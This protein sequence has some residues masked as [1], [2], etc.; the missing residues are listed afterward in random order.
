MEVFKTGGEKDLKGKLPLHLVPP[1]IGEA[2]AEVSQVGIQKGYTPRNWEKGLPIVEGHLAAMQR[3]VNEYLKGFDLNKEELTD[4]TFSSSHHL[5]HAAWHLNAAVTQVMR[6]RY[7]LDDRPT[8]PMQATLRRTN[9]SVRN[10]FLG[11]KGS[12]D[13]TKEDISDG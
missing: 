6:S 1:E 5:K 11:V 9:L 3:H 4:G 13:D 10:S 12:F 7:D 8:N 2:F